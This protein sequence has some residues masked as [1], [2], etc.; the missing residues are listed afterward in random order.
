M[1]PVPQQTS[2][3]DCTAV[4]DLIEDVIIGAAFGLISV[5]ILAAIILAFKI[6]T[7]R[8]A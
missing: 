5:L 8:D 7:E 1:K 2:L 6:L 4:S 3:F